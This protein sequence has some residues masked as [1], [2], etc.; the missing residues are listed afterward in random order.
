MRLTDDA[1]R[2]AKR[3]T[4]GQIF[5]WDELVS[6]FGVR[7]TPTRKDSATFVVQ[8]RDA[9]G[10][11]PRESIR[12][13]WPQ[14]SVAAAREHA[15]KRLGEV[16]AV[17][18]SS[19]GATLL[20]IAI[21]RW[22]ESE[23]VSGTWRPKYRTKVD[24]LLRH[25]V[26]GEGSERIKLTPTARAAIA[27]LGKQPVVMVSRTDILRVVDA[28]KRGAAEQLMAV[29][30]VFFNH[31][32]D[33][34]VQI[35]NPARNRLRYFGGRRTRS[36]LL[37]DAEFQQ[38]WKIFAEEPDPAQGAFALLV[39]TGARRREI[40]QL[41]WTEVDLAAG[42]ITL[43][44]ERRKTG[45]RDPEPFVIHLHPM[46]VAILKRQPRLQGSPFVFWGRRD[47]RPFDFGHSIMKRARG[48]EVADWRLHDLRRYM[49][50]GLARLGVSQAV[51]ELCLGHMA[52]KGGLVGVYDRYT[53]DA[54]KR[55]AWL[56][57][58]DH[59]TKLTGETRHD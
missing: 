7:L 14:L 46:A 1:V 11:K 41:R 54:E 31:Q 17:S 23:N 38:L 12:P 22:F 20:R 33:R 35:A 28:I 58:G 34:G 48:A 32:F 40:T 55:E 51:A 8:W 30:S 6:G 18:E 52:A 10:K 5:L 3:P 27:D 24:S 47:K 36:R 19:A 16:I 39:L 29:L 4:K 50:S 26:E 43:P 57:W 53:Y 9:N 44:P 37:S 49:R 45:K 21:R 56:K 59:V 25:Y 13:H 2:K 42:T 15:R